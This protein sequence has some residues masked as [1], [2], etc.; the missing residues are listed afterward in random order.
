MDSLEARRL[1]GIEPAS[2]YFWSPDNRFIVFAS[3]GKLKKVDASGGVPQD[4]CDVP[5]L[6]GGSWS[7]QGT[8]IFAGSGGGIARTAASGGAA[9]RVT[10]GDD[11]FPYFLPDGRHF[12]YLHMA[13]PEDTGIYLGALDTAPE[14]QSKKRLLAT[15]QNVQYVPSSSSGRGYILFYREGVVLAQP[16]DEG[17]LELTG[18]AIALVQGVGTFA[19]SAL[20]SASD[21]GVLAFRASTGTANRLAWYDRKGKVLGYL[22]EPGL[23]SDV[24][25]SPDGKRAVFSR[26]AN[27]IG[28]GM[29]LWLFDVMGGSS[30]RF[31]LTPGLNS[32]PVWSPDSATVVYSRPP[33]AYRRPATGTGSE[34]IMFSYPAVPEDWSRDGRYLL[35]SQTN[36]ST[37]WDLWALPDPNGAAASR[38]PLAVLNTRF[39]ETMGQFSPDGHWIV[40]VSDE[41]GRPEVYVRPFPPSSANGSQRAISQ[42]GGDQP[43]WRRDGREILYFAPDGNL[44]SAEVSITPTYAV[45]APRAVFRVPLVTT[46]IGGAHVHHWDTTGDGQRFL[47]D[48]NLEGRPDPVTVV[49][50]WPAMMNK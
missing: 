19:A 16:F 3:G 22:G 23:Y 38:Q 32:S 8:I 39:N 36:R 4:I 24:R 10:S 17:R 31:T 6:I 29:D 30:V 27:T 46:E 43:R 21:N 20:F 44:M 45:S 18:E 47:M 15:T 25:F 34:E 50:N 35:Y 48:V 1:N 14:R 40:Y 28:S 5:V 9:T 37:G 11:L 2:T 42:G 7:R 13:T 26:Y 41:S 33:S 49:L 12:L